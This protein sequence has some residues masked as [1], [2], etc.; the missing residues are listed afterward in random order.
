[1]EYAERQYETGQWDATWLCAYCWT[2]KTNQE[3]NKEYTVEEI[4][5]WLGINEE[6]ERE[7]SSKASEN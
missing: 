5:E 1:M 4:R 6:K 2:S 3:M 7:K